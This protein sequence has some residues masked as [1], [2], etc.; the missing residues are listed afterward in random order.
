MLRVT[1]RGLIAHKLRLA[2][3]AL[4]ILLGVAFMS[5]TLV[6]TATIGATFDGL[7]A[8]INAG[9]D[10]QVRSAEVVDTEFGEQRGTLDE[11]I[12]AEVAAVDGVRTASPDV[13]GYA[14]FVDK[15]GR[16][17]GNPNQGAPTLGFNWIEDPELSPLNLAAGRPPEGDGEVVMDKGTADA[18]GFEVGDEVTVL[19]ASGSE[20]F[21]VV[22]TTR[23]GKVD[24]PLGATLAVFD[25]PTAQRVVG[26]PGR[27][28]AVSVIAEEGV[29]P[30][31]L[32]A[33]L[34]AALPET[35][36]AITGAELTEEQQTQT[37]QAL[38]FFNTFLLV[39]AL[40]ALFVGS[41]IIYN[42]FSIIVAQRTREMAL[43][44]AI[45]AGRR[46]V[47]G[48]VM[49]EALVTG[50]LASALGVV[51]GLGVAVV[52]RNLFAL[53]G[54]DI[55]AT[56]LTIEP[57]AVVIPLVVGVVI[58]LA[59]A[60]FPARKAS[61]VPPIAAMRDVAIDESGRSLTRM[62]AGVAILTLGIVMVAGG[63][64]ADIDNAV[65]LVGLGAAVTF[66]GV[67][68]LGPVLARPLAG[69]LASPLPR[70]RGIAG[71]LARENAMR[72][73][74]R[75]SATAA[76]LMIGVG[77]VGF[78]TIVA[79]SASTSIRGTVDEGFLGDLVVQSNA[80]IGGGLPPTVA[81]G[82]AA[83]PEVAVVSS[84]RI[85]PA[86]V[87]GSG[88]LLYA[89][90]ASTFVQIG[91]LQVSAGD[92]TALDEPGT[93]AVYQGTADEKGLALG[94]TVPVVYPATGAQELEVVA[95]FDEQQIL[96]EYATGLATFE[97][98]NDVQLD[99]FVYLQLAPG[100][101]LDEGR[102]AVAAVTD[103]FPNADLQ[104]KT[105]FADSIVGQINQ[106]LNLVYVLLLLAVVIALIGIANTLALSIFERTRELG[107]LR[108]VGM[109][110]RQLRS[111]VRWESVI[112]AVMGTVLG[113]VI[114]AFF[115]WA[116][117]TSLRSEGFTDL[118]FPVVQLVVVVVMAAAAGVLAAVPPARRA[119]RL[120]VL[121]AIS[122]E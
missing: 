78:I 51:A 110:R 33:R 47:L 94:D 89:V 61:R 117:V 64:W 70:L 38:G 2:T 114:G 29:G 120:D 35:A 25:L 84:E 5:G 23:F 41:F 21:T 100:V 91:D 83:L 122:T 22:G 1:L 32:A 17:I 40:I 49:V 72:N 63:L 92:L 15:D 86:L 55:P 75:T 109:T 99:T 80:G 88:T 101:S 34:D 62:L 44:R 104:D 54:I 39:F 28:S 118:T 18:N 7:Y 10:V 106:L 46:Q 42:T 4:A 90:D 19:S 14:Q 76:A 102:A 73:P 66:L 37:R 74:K 6:L 115:G 59:S 95:F 93:I 8:D 24:S 60:Y 26:L 53:L 113:L 98:N 85:G 68:V 67:A 43:L 30:D 36:Q 71:R 81:S 50:V 107:L 103:P 9:T 96:G 11:G 97:A 112:I 13:T 116:L 105:E 16:A 111:A 108:A 119:A 69:A 20:A 58:T 87:D 31:D 57:S 56:G 82:I 65:A 27:L 121:R 52:L 79:A 48:S 45:G 3:T 77:L 12:V